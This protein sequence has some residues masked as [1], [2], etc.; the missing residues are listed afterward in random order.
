MTQENI[1]FIKE[2]FSFIEK[3]D[4]ALDRLINHE[5][6]D[7]RHIVALNDR[8]LQALKNIVETLFKEATND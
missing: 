5:D 4:E 8:K 3:Y 6:V 7:W 1:D 2:Q